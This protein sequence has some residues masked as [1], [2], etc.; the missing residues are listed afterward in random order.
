MLTKSEK[1]SV[2]YH[3]LFDYPLNY[4]DVL[5]WRIG[6]K[7]PIFNFQFSITNK[8]GFYFLEGREVLVHKRLSRKRISARKM[9][10][11]KNVTRLLKFLPTVKMVA[12]TGSLAMENSTEESDIDLLIIT[13]KETLW[14]TRLLIYSIL[15]ICH[16]S[17]R[18]PF[19]S[20]QKD[21]LCL[22]MWM[23]ESD[24]IWKKSDRNLYTAHEIA[25]IVPLVNK[26]KIYEK[27]LYKNKWILNYW[28]SAVKIRNSKRLHHFVGRMRNKFEFSKFKYLNT[29]SSFVFRTSN[30][31]AFKMQYLHMKNKISR[32]V[33]TPTRAIFHPRDWGKIILNR[34]SY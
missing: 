29:V 24:L 20:N 12:V 16:L 30:L 27:F 17:F 32:E 18:R 22:N 13:K 10:I 4:A 1:A 31:I 2:I 9:Q 25:Q 3:N 11:V 19:D 5:K 34:L 21:A 14:I 8:R 7:L 23:D 6:K 28:P 33:V 26:D 15:V